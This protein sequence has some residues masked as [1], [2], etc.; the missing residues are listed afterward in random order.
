MM[1]FERE[2]FKSSFCS[3]NKHIPWLQKSNPSPII[4]SFNNFE[5]LKFMWML[6]CWWHDIHGYSE[7]GWNLGWDSVT[8]FIHLILA[9]SVL[10]SSPHVTRTPYHCQNMPKSIYIYI[11]P[12]SP[13]STQNEFGSHRWW[14]QWLVYMLSTKVANYVGIQLS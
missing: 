8:N 1:K 12:V 10:V 11:D 7:L 3:K 4:P 2:K 5:T 14:C 6:V 13:K 9:R